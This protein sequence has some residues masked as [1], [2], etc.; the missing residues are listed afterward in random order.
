[1]PCS[2]FSSVEEAYSGANGCLRGQCVLRLAGNV[3]QS[4]PF[5]PDISLRAISNQQWSQVVKGGAAGG[6]SKQAEP[7]GGMRNTPYTDHVIIF[8]GAL[9]AIRVDSTARRVHEP[10]RKRQ[11]TYAVISAHVQ[12]QGFGVTRKLVAGGVHDQSRR[13]AE[14]G[15]IVS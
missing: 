3:H 6:I 5:V 9:H 8:V 1:M 2:V 13:K 14:I 15:I 4:K 7:L 12:Q 11:R 10:S